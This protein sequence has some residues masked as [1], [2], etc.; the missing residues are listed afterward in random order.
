M[1]PRNTRPAPSR[2]RLL[3]LDYALG[4]AIARR[5]G[6]AARQNARL[7]AK[8]L[9]DWAEQ[10]PEGEEFGVRELADRLRGRLEEALAAR[11]ALGVEI[12]QLQV[13][14]KLS[15]IPAGI[16]GRLGQRAYRA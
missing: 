10:A 11:E 5:D 1:N 14:R 13:Q 4:E 12:A 9:Q 15:G 3:E 16:P 6:L 8:A 7:L 2:E